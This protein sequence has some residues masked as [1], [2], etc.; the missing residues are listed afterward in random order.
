LGNKLSKIAKKA[1]AVYTDKGII[2]LCVAASSK[3]KSDTF[4]T[5]YKNPLFRKM[6]HPK[7]KIAYL[8]VTNNCNLRCKMCIYSQMKQTT[9]YMSR[10]L[11]ENCVNQLSHM[12][13]ET[14]YLHFGGE[15][16]V[17][18]DFQDYLRYAIKKRNQGGIRKIAWIDNGMLFNQTISDLAL[19]LGVDEIGFSIDGVGEINDKIRIGANYSVIEKNIK[20]LIKKRGDAKKPKI[21]LSMCDYGK[22]EEQKMDVYRNWV[23]FVDSITLIPSIL[24]DNTWENK[25]DSLKIVEPPAFCAFPFDTMAISWD[26]KV[27]GCCLDYVFKMDLG[28]ANKESLR[29]IWLGSNYQALRLAALKNVFPDDSLCHKCDFWKINFEPSHN[30]ILD[31]AATIDSGYIYRIIKRNSINKN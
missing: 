29:K 16:L 22:T 21:H 12:D 23:Q 17:H 3:L 10:V 15:S 18:P 1:S 19:D 8:E 31:G 24:P 30:L 26:G 2:G 5:L 6:M 7:L 13:I 25:N 27:T 20:Y 28:D 14:L 4:P 9:G 11:F